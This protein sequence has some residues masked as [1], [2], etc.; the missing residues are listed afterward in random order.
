MLSMLSAYA[1]SAG[2]AERAPLTSCN[3]SEIDLQM[4]EPEARVGHICS[5]V[6]FQSIDSPANHAFVGAYRARF[7]GT[8]VTCADAEASYAAVR[9][10]AEAIRA[11]GSADVQRVRDC[12]A[13]CSLD[14]PQGTVRVDAENQHSF[15]T[16][17]LG[18]S[19][20]NGHFDI[21]LAAPEP[22][23]PD[24]YLVWFDARRDVRGWSATAGGW[25]SPRRQPLRAVR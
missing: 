15:L 5:A 1:A 11:C 21:V 23:K 14:A 19:T 6:Y 10:L 2:E 16:P 4:V 25:T 9:L 7:G 17:R 24:P 3:L 20:A 12:I 18:R 13:N 8:K 22:V